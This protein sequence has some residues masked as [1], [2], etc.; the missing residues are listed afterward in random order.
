MMNSF[1]DVIDC[2]GRV[3]VMATAIAAPVATVRKWRQ[4]DSIPAEWWLSIERAAGN[5]F[6]E[7]VS[8]RACVA[9]REGVPPD[10]LPRAPP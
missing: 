6:S 3:D 1:R 9:A 8:T 7:S 4:R 2:W 10:A 5:R